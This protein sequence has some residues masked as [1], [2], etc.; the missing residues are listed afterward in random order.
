[1]T[2]DLLTSLAGLK[3]ISLSL[4]LRGQ[5]SLDPELETLVHQNEGLESLLL[6]DLQVRDESLH[7]IARLQHL[8]CLSV[9][10][11]SFSS[12]GALAILRGKSR[13]VLLSIRLFY[14]EEA[15]DMQAIEAEVEV[16]RQE[17]GS[18]IRVETPTTD[19]PGLRIDVLS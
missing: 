9:G 10:E 19:G 8:K 14:F 3:E 4:P 16:L 1:M 7:S 5:R 18:R 12:D 6:G 2:A 17:R 11:G 15:L 13:S